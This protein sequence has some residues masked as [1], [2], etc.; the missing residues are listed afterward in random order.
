MWSTS[1]AKRDNGPVSPTPLYPKVVSPEGAPIGIAAKRRKWRGIS[2]PERR[3]PESWKIS[4]VGGGGDSLERTR[5]CANSLLT[6]KRTGNF[7]ILMPV[8]P[9]RKA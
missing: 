4:N 5:L 3:D 9:I 7:V 6:G 8:E 1:L 2:N